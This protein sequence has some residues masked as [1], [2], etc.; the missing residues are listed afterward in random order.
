MSENLN[1]T[2]NETQLSSCFN[3]TAEK[4]GKSFANCLIFFVSLAGNA[5][6][7]IIVYKRKTMRKPNNYL[8]VNMAMSD[9]LVPIFLIPWEIQKLYIDSWLIS[10]PLGQ[11]LC[12]LVAF[13]R[14]VSF[15]V[16]VQSLVLIAVDR[17]GAVVVPLRYPLISSK[18]CPFFILATWIVAMAVIS[19]YLFAMELFEYPGGRL[20]CRL[21]W[22]EVFGDSFESYFMVNLMVFIFM[23]FVLISILSIIIFLKLKSLKIPSEQSA[24]AET[25]Q[26]RQREHHVL[27]MA[28]A[29][30]SGFA[31]RALPVLIRY[32]L[33]S[34]APDMIMS[35]G[36]KHFSSVAF[37]MV[38]LNCALNPCICLIFSSS[39]RE[40]LKTLFR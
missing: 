33:V 20:G 9:L 2:M 4:I 17:F 34:F 8:I 1:T 26:R 38:N 24:N 19:P 3:P 10:G 21:R 22:E 23:P 28:T 7:G 27:K 6:I 36:F 12:K 29:I 14:D 31:I 37:L 39:Y 15:L 5:V 18:L 35:C 16:S 30:M 13:A 32:L 25:E 11:A 40:G